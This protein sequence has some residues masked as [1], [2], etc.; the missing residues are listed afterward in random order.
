MWRWRVGE[1]DA[2]CEVAHCVFGERQGWVRDLTSIF[3]K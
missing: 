2:S 3:V 1:K